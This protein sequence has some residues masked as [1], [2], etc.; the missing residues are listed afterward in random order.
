MTE[1]DVAGTSEPAPKNGPEGPE[2][3][4][5]TR[6]KRYI[7]VTVVVIGLTSMA[8]ILIHQVYYSITSGLISRTANVQFPAFFCVP[9]AYVSALILVLILRVATGPVEFEFLGLKFRGSSGPLVFWI[10]C[11]LSMIWAFNVL[12]IWN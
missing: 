9:I 4:W 7:I 3:P 2:H 1:P 5:D 8:A 6:L 11:F 12:W 10:L